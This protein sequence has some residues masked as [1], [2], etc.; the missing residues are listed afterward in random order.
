MQ[1]VARAQ[2]K[3]L[4]EARRHV[5]VS[6]SR[7]IAVPAVSQETGLIGHHFQ[8]ARYSVGGLSVVSPFGLGLMLG[9]RSK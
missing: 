9:H 6:V 5:D 3:P 4:H 1:F 2:A 7:Q 8:D